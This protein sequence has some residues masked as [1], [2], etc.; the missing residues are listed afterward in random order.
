MAETP[1]N[2]SYLANGV[3]LLVAAIEHFTISQGGNISSYDGSSITGKK[4]M[5]LPFGPTENSSEAEESDTELFWIPERSKINLVN[6]TGIRKRVALA[7]SVQKIGFELPNGAKTEIKPGQNADSVAANVSLNGKNSILA[8][9]S[10]LVDGE[11]VDISFE[12]MGTRIE[13][14]G[15]KDS[16]VFSGIDSPKI[17]VNYDEQQIEKTVNVRTLFRK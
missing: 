14:S 15:Q 2:P 17:I 16:A 4:G 1:S 12:G 9:Y 7:T 5:I 10:Y 3:D 6:D 11:M 8:Q 13:V